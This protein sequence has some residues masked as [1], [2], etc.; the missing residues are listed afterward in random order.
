MFLRG[1]ERQFDS[2][3]G[4]PTPQRPAEQDRASEETQKSTKE[5]E[6]ETGN[7]SIENQGNRAFLEGVSCSLV[8][9]TAGRKESLS[10]EREG[11]CRVKA[12]MSSVG[13]LS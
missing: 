8:L 2:A 3:G 4:K 13:T 6:E 5:A 12:L 7:S 1:G 9:T 10:L 11:F